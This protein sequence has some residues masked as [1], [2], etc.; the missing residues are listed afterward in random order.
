MSVQIGD[1][2]PY[3]SFLVM[4]ENG[5]QEVNVTEFFAD[6]TVILFAVPG[7]FTPTCS[8]RH[9]PGFV[10]HYDEFQALGVNEIMC[11]SVNDVFVMNA[12]SQAQGA[13]KI[14]M[15]A[16]NSAEFTT[17]L[18]LEIDIATAQM[19]LR[20]RRYAML[21]INGV[22]QQLWLEEPGEFGVSSAEHVLE[23]IS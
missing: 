4:G 17:A 3:G 18:G 13:E 2:L 21:V 19:G 10:E 22:I 9:L 1:M 8:A 6:K 5:P 12:W 20:S 7:A 15:A 14:V 23:Q 16:D 11:L